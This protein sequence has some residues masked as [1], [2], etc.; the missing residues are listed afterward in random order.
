ML[1]ISPLLFSSVMLVDLVLALTLTSLFASAYPDRFRTALW[2]NGGSEGWNSDPQQRVYDYANY[3]DST[4]FHLVIAA[5]TLFVWIVRFQVNCLSGYV[6]DLHA[7]IMTNAMYDMLL[8]GL[9]A[10]STAMQNSGD[11]SD[12]EHIS[13]RPWYLERGC[14]D[15]WKRTWGGCEVMRVS[16]GLTI[17]AVIWYCLRFLTTCLYLAYQLG[18]E[19]EVQDVLNNYDELSECKAMSYTP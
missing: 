15:A 2:Q 8:V 19:H 7:S 3:R 17:F 9:Y 11:F 16:Y 18:R 10:S 6:L 14:E 13:L 5:I 4:V 1:R 12:P